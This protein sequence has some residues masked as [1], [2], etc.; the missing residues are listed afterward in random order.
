[1]VPKFENLS[2]C[3]LPKFD[4]QAL[5]ISGKGEKKIAFILY[6]DEFTPDTVSFLSKIAAAV[7]LQL[8]VDAFLVRFSKDNSCLISPLK[9]HLAFDTSIIFGCHPKDLG[10]HFK[11]NLYE[12]INCSSTDFLF[13]DPLGVLYE[14]RQNGGKEKSK[15]LWMALK[16]L[17]ELNN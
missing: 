17:F 12:K 6:E 14:E 15:R 13:A 3:Q 5:S 2:V 1:M 11:V 4:Y 8:E 10:L 7:G 16:S 9:H